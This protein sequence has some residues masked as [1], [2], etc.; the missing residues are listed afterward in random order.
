MSDRAN[1]AERKRLDFGHLVDRLFWA[2]L[3]VAALYVAGQIKAM[4]ENVAQLNEKMAV[5]LEKIIFT[6]RRADSVEKRIEKVEDKLE[7]ERR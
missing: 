2:L 4:S 5:V 7:N 1:Y 6:E 3:T